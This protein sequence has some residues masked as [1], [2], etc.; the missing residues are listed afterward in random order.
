MKKTKIT[1]T[2]FNLNSVEVALAVS[3][4]IMKTNNYSPDFM[5]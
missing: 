1:K 3:N 5:R 4:Y 2:I